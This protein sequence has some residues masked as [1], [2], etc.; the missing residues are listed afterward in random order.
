MPVRSAIADR[1]RVHTRGRR[2]LLLDDRAV[3][4]FETVT[5]TTEPTKIEQ[6]DRLI[7]YLGW[8]AVQAI[9][10]DDR[11]ADLWR[12]QEIDEN[13]VR[14]DL[15]PAERA[16]HHAERKRLYEREHPE[17]RN[18]ATGRGRPKQVLQNA[19]PIEHQAA[20]TPG[21]APERA[22]SYRNCG[23]LAVRSSEIA[24]H[25]RANKAGAGENPRV[26]DV[27]IEL[28]VA[29]LFCTDLHRTGW[30]G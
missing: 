13:L 6:M 7:H 11:S 15:S 2:R 29:A 5:D 24:G 4:Q 14:A 20:C 19:K 26:K 17:T 1:W 3:A 8:S 9:I 18:G 10:S 21:N 23:T 12:L 27:P 30:R 16:A 28:H 25:R 22:I